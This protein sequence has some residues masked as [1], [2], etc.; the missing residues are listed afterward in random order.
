[1]NIFSFEVL[2]VLQQLGRVELLV[3]SSATTCD[4]STV[5]V[6]YPCFSHFTHLPKF[7]AEDR[8]HERTIIT[9]L[10]GSEF[11]DHDVINEEEFLGFEEVDQSLETLKIPATPTASAI[12]SS[13]PMKT[14]KERV[15]LE[16]VATA[17]D[18]TGQLWPPSN[19]S[20]AR[21]LYE[22]DYAAER[23][24]TPSKLTQRFDKRRN[25]TEP[26][27]ARDFQSVFRDLERWLMQMRA[28]SQ[29]R[30]I[31]AIDGSGSTHRGSK[32]LQLQKQGAATPTTH[33]QISNTFSPRRLKSEPILSTEQHCSR[34]NDKQHKERKGSRA[35]RLSFSDLN[36][37][38]KIM[39]DAPFLENLSKDK[40]LTKQPWYHGDISRKEAIYRL[41]ETNPGTFLL[42]LSTRRQGITLSLMTSESVKHFII[43]PSN[44][45]FSIFGRD[46]TFKSI[47]KLVDYYRSSALSTDG[48]SLIFPC[49]TP[50]NND[51]NEHAY[52]E[53]LHSERNEKV[54]EAV[55]E[56]NRQ[57]QIEHEKHEQAKN[58]SNKSL[59]G[60]QQDGNWNIQRNSYIDSLTSGS[61]SK[62][63]SQ[64]L[65]QPSNDNECEEIIWDLDYEAEM[66]DDPNNELL[67]TSSFLSKSTES[68]MWNQSRLGLRRASASASTVNKLAASLNSLSPMER[69][70][71]ELSKEDIEGHI[72][73]IRQQVEV[74]EYL[75]TTEK[76]PRSEITRNERL[77]KL[78]KSLKSYEDHLATLESI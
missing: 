7:F 43:I 36:N 17:R 14:E 42:R 44:S 49:P 13:T 31:T 35:R 33:A 41:S 53:F 45:M 75:L 55:A 54:M 10:Q 46:G 15:A 3:I 19:D 58:F 60:S 37:K 72:D 64:A 77:I 66:E 63:K 65:H 73:D 51:N 5:I 38:E 70:N 40:S 32:T 34:L 24:Q 11:V 50:S 4:A 1:M 20:H 16:L 2:Q 9:R 52:V 39:G 28:A 23:V 78:K 56:R 71:P 12:Q 47:Q 59:K 18:T 6:Y 61:G 48:T 74:E 57:R 30:Q 67:N 69:I 68:A 25:I 22:L 29:P 62:K 21:Q 76:M 27:Y 8:H 26:V